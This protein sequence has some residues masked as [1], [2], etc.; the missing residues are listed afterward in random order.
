MRA[1]EAEEAEKTFKSKQQMTN[2]NDMFFDA[3]EFSSSNQQVSSILESSTKPA[4]E[5]QQEP[6]I[7]LDDANWGND[8]DEIDIDTGDLDI[9]VDNNDQT[10]AQDSVQD[11]H[12][13]I[14]V[15]PSAGSDPLK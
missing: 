13:D 2:D 8:E 10:N 3:N 15:P 1:K 12:N 9:P 4:V 14:F 11:A 6:E 5:Q 7:A